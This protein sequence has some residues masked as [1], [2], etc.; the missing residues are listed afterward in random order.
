MLQAFNAPGPYLPSKGFYPFVDAAFFDLGAQSA[1]YGNGLFFGIF[2]DR[3]L[4]SGFLAYIH[5]V[6]G[7]DYRVVVGVQSAIFAVFPALLYLLGD[8]LHSKPAGLV[9]AALA[10]LKVSNAIAG[11]KLLSTS[12]PKLML[13]E[14]PTGVVLVLF[15]LFMVL[16]LREN[17]LKNIFP[18]R[19]WGFIGIGI[20]F[21]H[22]VFFMVPVVL[23]FGITVW[24]KNWAR[25]FRDILA[26]CYCLFYYDLSMDVA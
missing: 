19:Y 2:M 23:V 21:R 11:G 8:R 25:A 15:S 12:H 14:F 4:L 6:F 13:T 16:W 17:N 10:I 9:A 5:M 24:K 7:Q 18:C 20:L 26:T 3:G 1:I 22:N